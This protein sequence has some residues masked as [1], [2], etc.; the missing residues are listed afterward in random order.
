MELQPF[1]ARSEE[2]QEIISEPPRWINRWGMTL[3]LALLLMALLL[4]WL[5]RY[6]DII[7]AQV[8]ITSSPP[9]VELISRS[10]GNIRLI[11][12]DN[13]LVKRNEVIAYL[14]S[15]ADPLHV[16]DLEQ[17]II[18]QNR[19]RIFGMKQNWALG[20][21]EPYFTNFYKACHEYESFIE[22]NVYHNQ[23]RQIQRQSLSY[24]KLNNTMASQ[25]QLAREELEIS[26]EKFKRD[27]TLY[28]ERVLSKQD[29]NAA[30]TIYLQQKR[31]YRNAEANF[32]SNEI[33]IQ[34]LGKQ[35]GDLTAGSEN[36]YR[37]LLTAKENIQKE[38]LAAISK[39][40]ETFL[41]IAPQDGTVTYLKFLEN[42][43]FTEAGLP[44]FSVIPSTQIIYAQAEIP[45]TGSGKVKVGQT[46]NIR[47][48]NFP[49][50]EYGLVTGVID[51]LSDLPSN[52]KYLSKISL[53]SSLI[54]TYKR[55]LP[56][57]NSLRGEAD[58]ITEDLR[59]IDRI[60]YR[61]KT[62]TSSK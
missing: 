48:E 47:L 40:K 22:L 62:L 31:N 33:Q 8:V 57:K 15:A 30:Q 32:I 29:Y 38:L 4:S 20:E 58:I 7:K 3:I 53:P 5:I 25:L 46:V 55:K 44:L 1:E 52:D 56:F 14:N 50:Q 42:H 45:V 35:I 54:T 61:I 11:K 6:P 9:P 21:L 17:C 18:M 19:D 10:S 49:Y 2:I 13:E 26:A 24:Q 51:Q 28:S 12:K 43:F 39:W 59:V 41:F 36:D 27:S 37:R 23:I 60:F 34:V 16:M